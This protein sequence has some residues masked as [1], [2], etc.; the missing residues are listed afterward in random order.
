M[1]K[2]G[3]LAEKNILVTGA[4]SGIGETVSIKLAAEGA[5]VIMISRT[6]AQLKKVQEQLDGAG[7]Y[8]VQDLRCTEE[9]KELVERITRENGKLDGMV[10]CA[11]ISRTIPLKNSNFEMIHDVMLI[12]FY[13]FV[14]LSRI[15][16]L[17]KHFNP[18]GGGI[19]GISS[20]ASFMG[21]KGKVA[22]SAS[23]AAMDGA[24]RCMSAE[25]APKK[26]RV[27]SVS[28][29]FVR[30]RMYDNYVKNLGAEA[31]EADIAKQPLGLGDAEDVA[32]AV[33]F[34]LSDQSG[35][36]TG[37]TLTVDG[38]RTAID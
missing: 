33:L 20:I 12:N 31:A 3:I 23:K 14:E 22:Y 38:G 28:P 24:I 7:I 15:I 19:V 27:N 25:L 8:Y 26:I 2:A 30:T 4:S 1:N 10:H 17:K 34:L 18:E 6:E 32:N 5:K 35:F 36:I 21:H 11:G 29:G 9:I 37:T 16:C 13:A